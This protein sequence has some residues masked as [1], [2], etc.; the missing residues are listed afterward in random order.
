[1]TFLKVGEGPKHVGC[2]PQLKD[3]S[4]ERTKQVVILAVNPGLKNG[5]YTYYASPVLTSKLG[6]MI[7]IMKIAKMREKASTPLTKRFQ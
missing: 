7:L 4:K 6:L 2:E 1:M 5:V 3:G